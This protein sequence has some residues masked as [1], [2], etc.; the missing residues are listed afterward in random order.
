M[1]S[2]QHITARDFQILNASLKRQLIQGKLALQT[3]FHGYVYFATKFSS[4]V[5]VG[6]SFVCFNRTQRKKKITIKPIG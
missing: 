4:V 6:I 3:L 5:R 2:K 1:A